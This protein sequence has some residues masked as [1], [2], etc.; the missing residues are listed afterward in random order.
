M[1]DLPPAFLQQ[2]AS[3]EGAYLSHDDPIRQSGFGGGAERW[4]AE[5][6]PILEAVTGDGDFLDVGCANGYLAEC[7]VAWAGER[8]IGLTPHGIDLGPRLIAEAQRRLPQF[9]A[10][11]HVANGWDWR[12]G[13]RFRYV[14]TLSDCVPQEMLRQYAGRLLSRLV[15]PHGRLIVG[16]YGSR[17]RATPPL[18]IAETLA[19]YGYAVAGQITGGQPPVTTF[20]WIDRTA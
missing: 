17:S 5:R 8:G 15:E 11:F 3:L 1:S 4:R 9:A 18:P 13:R 19:S 2:V 10:N 6:G 16:S 7:L 20:A 14:Y 12:P